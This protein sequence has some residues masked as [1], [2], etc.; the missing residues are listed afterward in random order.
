MATATTKTQVILAGPDDWDEWIEI[1]QTTTRKA[2]IW[3]LVNPSTAKEKLP[4]LEPPKRPM[5]DDVKETINTPSGSS[6]TTPSTSTV[7]PTKFSQLT[8]DE[9]EQ[10]RIL[11]KDY[12][13][14]RKKYN[15][16]TDALNDLRVHI[17]STVERGQLSYTFKCENPY[18]MLVKLKERFAPTNR[19]REQESIREWKKL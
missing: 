6:Q 11:Q 12:K 4:K 16:R 18:D 3:N 7:A 9:K 14:E 5:P 10:L 1:V 2:D 19:A 15:Q 8:E 17:Q 13:Y